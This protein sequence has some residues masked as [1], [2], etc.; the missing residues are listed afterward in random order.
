MVI[1]KDFQW[2]NEAMV[3]AFKQKSSFKIIFKGKK[4][5]N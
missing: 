2:K 1:S 3:R 5:K 4:I